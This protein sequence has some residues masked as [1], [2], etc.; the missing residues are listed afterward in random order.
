MLVRV[1]IHPSPRFGAA[2]REIGAAALIS[3]NALRKRGRFRRIKP[4]AFGGHDD[5]ALDSAGFVAMFRYGGYPW[6]V[7]EYLDLVASW[8]W[9]WWAAMD[10]CCEPEIARNRDEVRRRVRQTVDKLAEC[11]RDA[12]ARSLRLPMPVLQGWEPDDYERCAALMPDLPDLVGLGSVCRRNLGGDAGLFS[13]LNRL[14]R[15]LPENVRLHLFGVKGAAIGALL[16]HPRVASVDSMAWD[17]GARK[18]LELPRT[19]TKKIDFMCT[20][21]RD[22][23]SARSLFG[24]PS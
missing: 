13:I 8:P 3:A 6:T 18:T 24:E 12:A 22:Q 7:A 5:I 21:W 1:G 4:G 2:L 20:W 10:F 14:D 19:V 17:M 9:T 15:R 23:T 11:R 16:G